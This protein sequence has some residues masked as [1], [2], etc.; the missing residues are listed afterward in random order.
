MEFLK[1]PSFSG[2]KIVL[3]VKTKYVNKEDHFDNF[4]NVCKTGLWQTHISV[5][6]ISYSKPLQ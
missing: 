5:N 1:L 6:Y 3:T 4:I 2:P